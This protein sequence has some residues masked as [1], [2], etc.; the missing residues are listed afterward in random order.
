MR[1]PTPVHLD[2]TISQLRSALER[3]PE[4]VALITQLGLALGRIGEWEAA[5]HYHHMA[6]GLKPEDADLHLNLGLAKRD[7][8]EIDSAIECFNKALQYKPDHPE[9]WYKLGNAH[10]QKNQLEK[11]ISC[12]EMAIA[13]KP[14]YPEALINL[15]NALASSGNINGAIAS[16]RHSLTL[17][18][19]FPEAYNNLGNCLFK[20]DDLE[21]AISCY[22]AALK[23]RPD[24]GDAHN[25]LG[26]A[27]RDNCELQ[28]AKKSHRLALQS[29]PDN[30]DYLSSYSITLLHSEDY[31]NG[32]EM[33]ASRFSRQLNP[34]KTDATP[35]SRPLP[36]KNWPADGRILIVSEQGIGDTLQFMRYVKVLID[37][38]LDVSF[39]THSFLHPLIATSGIAAKLLLPDQANAISDRPWIPLLSVPHVLG[40]S[41]ANP[42]STAPYIRPP[43]GCV[44]RWG[45]ILA[46]EQRPII[47]I[48]WQGNP[49]AERSGLRG[50]SLPLEALAPIASAREASLLS[51]QKGHGSEQLDSCSFRDRFVSIQEQVN[52]AWDFEETA[53]IIANCDLV[54]TSDTA[55]AH[56]AGGMGKA[57]WL[58]LQHVPDWRWG[59]E[60]ERSFWYPSMRLFRQRERGDWAGVIARVAAALKEHPL[61]PV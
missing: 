13:F 25:N 39:C 52:D 33:Y 56:L 49:E 31:T 28:A 44:A 11:A 61:R 38:G 6:L 54:I 1:E 58:L 5:I 42:I 36:D 21:Q 12:Y 32:W 35:K 24:F 55:V 17:A 15:G 26:N 18:S 30:A 41:P 27:L 53:A 10:L 34:S 22:R 20:I 43:D 57:T 59:L 2:N 8:G 50:R 29:N 47:G 45:A 14:E 23:L 3:N 46:A 60:G 48:N 16:Y 51:L 37:S 4:N 7:S 19:P 40:V 9:A